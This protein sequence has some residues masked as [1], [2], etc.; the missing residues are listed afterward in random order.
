MV[1]IS[2]LQDFKLDEDNKVTSQKLTCLTLGSMANTS[3]TTKFGS[4]FLS[5]TNNVNKNI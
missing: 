5:E 1:A 2:N 3:N 4:I